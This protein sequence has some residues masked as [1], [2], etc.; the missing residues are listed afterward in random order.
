M[1]WATGYNGHRMGNYWALNE[2]RMG[3]RLEWLRMRL[4]VESAVGIEK[5]K[6]L[7][8]GVVLT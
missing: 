8:L 1:E 6:A 3:G 4:G 5:F 2:H 7:I